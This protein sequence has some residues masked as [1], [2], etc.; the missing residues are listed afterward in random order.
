MS[1]EPA[2]TPT[3]AVARWDGAIVQAVWL[4]GKVEHG[5]DPREMRRDRCTAW[6]K[7]HDYQNP[8]SNFGWTIDHIRPPSQGGGDDLDNLQP[9]HIENHASK[10]KGIGDCPVRANG[11]KN[12]RR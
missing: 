4:K 3:G 12:V 1:S 11:Q 6:I 2:S 10:V 5:V 7:R 9:L 8:H